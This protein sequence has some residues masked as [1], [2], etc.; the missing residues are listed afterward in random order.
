MQAGAIRGGIYYRCHSKTL[1][2]GSPISA[3]HPKTV[4]LRELTLADPLNR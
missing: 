4:N 3:E 2:P 1:A